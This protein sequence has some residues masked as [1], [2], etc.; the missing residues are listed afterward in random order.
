MRQPNPSVAPNVEERS[1]MEHVQPNRNVERTI[2]QQRCACCCP[3]A[4]RFL[5][6]VV[7]Q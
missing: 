5:C 3:G 6:Y 4:L 2:Q 7:R 1:V